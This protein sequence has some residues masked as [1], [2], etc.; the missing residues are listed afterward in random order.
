MGGEASC[1][2]PVECVGIHGSSKV[3][4]QVEKGHVKPPIF[5]MTSEVGKTWVDNSR[6]IRIPL[7]AGKAHS[8]YECSQFVDGL[9]SIGFSQA[10]NV[11]R[12][13]FER[14]GTRMKRQPVPDRLLVI[15]PRF[16]S[17]AVFTSFLFDG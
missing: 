7:Q 4:D 10:G 16:C 6:I 14:F 17:H 2:K 11:A 3:L 12:N 8:S 1:Q 5:G 13:G 9:E 15:N